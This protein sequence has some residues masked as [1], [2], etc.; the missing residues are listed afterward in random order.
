MLQTIFKVTYLPNFI[1]VRAKKGV[2][3]V[4]HSSQLSCI[5]LSADAEKHPLE[6]I[7]EEATTTRKHK[8]N[9]V[10]KK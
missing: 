10:E 2:L 8:K 9:A 6:S 7:D 5:A 4:Y 3:G 1:F